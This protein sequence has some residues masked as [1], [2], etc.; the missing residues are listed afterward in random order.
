MTPHTMLDDLK[1]FSV[2]P[3]G[4]ARLRKAFDLFGVKAKRWTEIEADEIANLWGE[5][6]PKATSPESPG[7]AAQIALLDRL[8]F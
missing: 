2:T 8:N 1:L 4:K 5:V 7:G 6:F 3:E